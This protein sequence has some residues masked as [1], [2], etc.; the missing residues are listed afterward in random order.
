MVASS[1]ARTSPAG[2]P[3]LDNA[4]YD[5]A[6]IDLASRTAT[7]VPGAAADQPQQPMVWR[8]DGSRLFTTTI[9]GGK[10]YIAMWDV[11][12]GTATELRYHPK[13]LVGLAALGQTG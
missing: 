12:A 3:G 13:A 1:P 7:V 9:V 5:V 6:I 10:T 8:A 11:G 4:T 2:E